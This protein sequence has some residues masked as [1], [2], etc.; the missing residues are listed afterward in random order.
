LSIAPLLS[1]SRLDNV[2][3]METGCSSYDPAKE[4][5][6]LA[7]YAIDSTLARVK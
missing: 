4:R 7:N 2:V 6:R 5:I 3:S 1:V